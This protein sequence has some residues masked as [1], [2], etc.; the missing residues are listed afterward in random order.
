VIT[1]IDDSPTKVFPSMGRH[2]IP[3]ER[4][5]SPC[6]DRPL[7]RKPVRAEDVETSRRRGTK[8]NGFGTSV[9]PARDH[10]RSGVHTNDCQRYRTS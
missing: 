7:I 4:I 9:L 8:H 2:E 5:Q 6:P 1:S 3:T 10:I